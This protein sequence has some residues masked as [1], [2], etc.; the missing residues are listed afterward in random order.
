MRETL[1]WIADDIWASAKALHVR[2]ILFE[3]RQAEIC[4]MAAR[5]GEIRAAPLLHPLRRCVPEGAGMTHP[6]RKPAGVPVRDPDPPRA[7]PGS[8]TLPPGG[9]HAR[10]GR[11]WDIKRMKDPVSLKKP[12]L[13]TGG[14][15]RLLP[16][17]C[18]WGINDFE[19]C[20]L[21]EIGND[22]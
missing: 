2:R 4:P 15:Q 6:G 11:N 17:F 10:A 14:I 20:C 5:P 8:R 7:C 18:P 22:T 16:S 3:F 12:G 9:V 1:F 21:A 13:F 19:L